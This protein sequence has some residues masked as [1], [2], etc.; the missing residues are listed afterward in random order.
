MEVVD[1]VL[2]SQ[3][4]MHFEASFEKI[5]K[6]LELFGFSVKSRHRCREWLWEFW[7]S[8]IIVMEICRTDVICQLLNGQQNLVCFNCCRGILTAELR[9]TGRTVLFLLS[10]RC[11]RG[12][13]KTSS[14][15]PVTMSW[16]F[17]PEFCV[18]WMSKMPASGWGLLWEASSFVPW[19]ILNAFRLISG[20]FP[21]WPWISG[22]MRKSST[23]VNAPSMRFSVLLNSCDNFLV[24]LS[25]IFSETWVM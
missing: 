16:P 22:F 4:V 25:S 2:S 11:T 14:W 10:R 5:F 1:S 20:A 15:T 8:V 7:N 21:E 17:R 13:I 19:P 23:R 12:A 3:L 6:Q 24:T 9:L 18:I